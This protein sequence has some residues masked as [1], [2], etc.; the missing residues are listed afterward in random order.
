MGMGHG[1]NNEA[2]G[3]REGTLHE[4]ERACWTGLDGA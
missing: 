4:E 1:S 3:V 2:Y